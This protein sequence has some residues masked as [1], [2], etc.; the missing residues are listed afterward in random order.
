MGVVESSHHCNFCSL[1]SMTI[2][3]PL[4]FYKRC[5]SMRLCN[6]IQV[7]SNLH[8]CAFTKRKIFFQSKTV[9]LWFNSFCW[10]YLII[11]WLI[12]S[13]SSLF[14]LIFNWYCKE[15]FRLG[16]SW[17]FKKV[18]KYV[19]HPPCQLETNGI[20]HNRGSFSPTLSI[21]QLWH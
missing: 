3:S 7:Y 15:K 8:A 9:Q 16:H 5:L 11:P 20:K 14:C 19:L 17:Q 4:P 10:C 6:I 13:F 12:F 18:D 2:N 1:S 21:V